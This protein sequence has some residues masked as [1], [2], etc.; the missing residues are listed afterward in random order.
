MTRDDSRMPLPT[1][2]QGHAADADSDLPGASRYF[3]ALVLDDTPQLLRDSYSLR[4]Q[5]YCLERRF[6]PAQDYPDELE[7][8]V[9]DPHSVH[10][11][12]VNLQGAVV[13]TARLVE[14]SDAGLPLLDH[15]T[16]FSHETSPYDPTRRV[17]ELS[18]LSVSRTYNRRKGDGFYSLQGATDRPDGRERRGGGEIVLI[19]YRAL[20]Q[21]SR[22]RRHTHW[23]AATEKSLQRLLTRYGV[24]FREIG[25]ETDYYGSVTPYLVD[26]HEWDKVILSGR[27]S[28]LDDFLTGLE[29]EFRP[30]EDDVRRSVR[31]VR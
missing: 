18:R 15:C 27:I 12:V 25:P 1:D 5:V 23:F 13:A 6:L 7:V 30:A 11:G 14:L 22:R 4:Y 2:T 10:V 31:A 19:L 28:L 29:A 8:D 9:F 17:A 24:P 3:T 20:Y 21:A 16:I 26:L